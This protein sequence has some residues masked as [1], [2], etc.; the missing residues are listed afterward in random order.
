VTW[1]AAGAAARWLPRAVAGA[2]LA[3][4]MAGGLRIDPA[5]SALAPWIRAF[6]V[7]VGALAALAVVRRGSEVRARFAV[8]ADGLVVR[9]GRHER[10]LPWRSMTRLEW[11]PPFAGA[12]TWLPAF[13]VVDDA[14]R[15][16]RVPA[17]VE[18]GDRLVDELVRRSGRNDLAAWAESQALR[19]RMARARSRVV[20][21]YA[22]AALAFAA[23]VTAWAS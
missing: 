11:L 19:D 21:G 20:I 6:V 23:A 3:A 15:A 1:Y 7:L 17:V 9:V 16:W 8:D 12:R 22:V 10:R 13:A 18:D 2:L 14:G 4:T 5:S